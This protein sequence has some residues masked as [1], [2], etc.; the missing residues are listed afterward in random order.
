[1]SEFEAL[2]KRIEE[3][4]NQ[5]AFQEEL[6]QRLNDVVA[7]QDRELLELREQLKKLASRLR[8]LG[9]TAANTPGPRDEV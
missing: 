9:E 2:A 4:E 8:E 6:H 5:A 1:M 3:L 7:R